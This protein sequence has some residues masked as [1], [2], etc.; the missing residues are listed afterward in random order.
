MFNSF[1]C[2][3][4]YYIYRYTLCYYSIERGGET[5]TI[6]CIIIV[7]VVYDVPMYKIIM[8]IRRCTL[9]DRKPTLNRLPR[10][11]VRKGLSEPR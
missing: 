5:G 8:Y 6:L 9:V 1:Y 10:D 7:V 2:F 4:L 11:T 3:I